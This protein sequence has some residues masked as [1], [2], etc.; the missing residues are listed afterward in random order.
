MEAFSNMVTGVMVRGFLF[1]FLVGE[2]HIDSLNISHL[3]FTNDTLIFCGAKHDQSWALRALQWCFEAALRLKVNLARSEVAS[4]GNVPNVG[5][6]VSI[7]GC[8][9]SQLPMKY[10]DLPLGAMI[11]SKTIW[12]DVLENKWDEIN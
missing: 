1:G 10:L 3:T 2:I 6:L 11:K 12:D 4:I 8:K 9:I 7:L 5:I